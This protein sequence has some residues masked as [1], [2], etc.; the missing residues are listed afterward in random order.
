MGKFHLG[1]EPTCQI[2]FS[3]SLPKGSP[4]LHLLDQGALSVERLQKEPS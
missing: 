3:Q 2:Q 1:L 4:A